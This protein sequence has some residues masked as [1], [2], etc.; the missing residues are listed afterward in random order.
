MRDRVFFLD[1]E[2]RPRI[3][4]R[5]RENHQRAIGKAR[6][7][8]RGSEINDA[9]LAIGDLVGRSRARALSRFQPDGVRFLRRGVIFSAFDNARGSSCTD[10]RDAKYV[11]AAIALSSRLPS[12]EQWRQQLEEER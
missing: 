2:H 9:V 1:I 4:Y 10:A 3:A 6:R 5:T 11:L 12:C 8:S 7:G